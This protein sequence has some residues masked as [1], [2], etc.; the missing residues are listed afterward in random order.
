MAEHT[1]Q[2]FHE[3]QIALFVQGFMQVWNKFEA[4]LS[5]ELVHIQ[6][7]LDG[8]HPAGGS[9]SDTN[10][11]LFYRVSSILYQ[12]DSLT[13]G[14]LS[15]TLSVPLS[16]ATRI[17]DWLVDNGYVNRWPD[18]EDRRVV[19]VALTD[20]GNELHGVI[21]DYIRQ[22]IEQVMACLSDEEKSTLLALIFRVVSGLKEA[23]S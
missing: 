2:K 13:M 21:D 16:T 9:H 11:A 20:A 3:Q 6:E 14:E 17:A 5:G 19:R 12:K 1:T 23:A 15:S 4:V 8:I 18:P 7:R 10:S 22:R